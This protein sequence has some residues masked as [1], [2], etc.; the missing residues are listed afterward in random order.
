MNG[1]RIRLDQSDDQA[2]QCRFAATARADEDRRFSLRD[3]EIGWRNR[4]GFAVRFTDANQLNQRAHRR[5]A[6]RGKVENTKQS[7]LIRPEMG[8]IEIGAGRHRSESFRRMFVGKFGHDCFAAVEMKF[9]IA[10]M[11]GLSAFAE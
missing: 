8:E 11:N 6:S 1:T 4:G 3:V 2:Q 10:E 9:A 5:L 7:R